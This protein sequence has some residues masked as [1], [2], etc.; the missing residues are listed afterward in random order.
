MIYIT[1]EP[2]VVTK[3]KRYMGLSSGT[4]DLFVIYT[5]TSLS[6]KP[7]LPTGSKYQHGTYTDPEA[8]MWESLS[9]AMC[10][11]IYSYTDPLG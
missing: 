10:I 11:Y 6:T 3:T 2:I 9:R 7:F 1:I 8:R 4:L 5:A